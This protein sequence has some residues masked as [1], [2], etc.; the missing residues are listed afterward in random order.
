M[1][2]SLDNIVKAASKYY[3]LCPHTHK[4]LLFLYLSFAGLSRIREIKKDPYQYYTAHEE[5]HIPLFSH[6]EARELEKTGRYSFPFKEEWE[7]HG[8]DKVVLEVDYS[9]DNGLHHIARKIQD[10]DNNTISTLYKANRLAHK[11]NPPKGSVSYTLYMLVKELEVCD[12]LV[13]QANYAE[14]FSQF[15]HMSEGNVISS[16]YEL[17]LLEKTMMGEGPKRIY[18]PYAGYSMIGSVLPSG[19]AI[20]AEIDGIIRSQSARLLMRGFPGTYRKFHDGTFSQNM[21]S[22]GSFDAVV[23]NYLGQNEDSFRDF[24]DC[25]LKVFQD[26]SESPILKPDGCFIGT[27]RTSDFET[28]IRTN[29]EFYNLL[30]EKQFLETVISVPRDLLVIKLSVKKEGE[31]RK[32][33]LLKLQWP[34]V[35]TPL[36][37]LIQT[38][39]NQICFFDLMSPDF[40]WLSH[41]SADLPER[42]GYEIY[43]L[44]TI[45]EP[46][47][48]KM[49][50]NMPKEMTMPT[51]IS[52]TREFPKDVMSAVFNANHAVEASLDYQNVFRLRR[53]ALLMKWSNDNKPEFALYSDRQPSHY[54]GFC[55]FSIE[56][57]IDYPLY[58]LNELRKGYVQKQI[59]ALP[60]PWSADIAA[61]DWIDRFLNVKIYVPKADQ[62][63]VFC[64]EVN[65][66]ILP[67]GFVIESQKAQ[68]TITRHLG[69]GAFGNV[70]LASRKDYTNCHVSVVALKELYISGECVRSSEYMVVP[71][72]QRHD[73]FARILE[74]FRTES[75][76]MEELSIIPDSHIVPILDS[77]YS[78]KTKT[79][80]Y[81]MEYQERGSLLDFLKTHDTGNMD[82]CEIIERFIQPVG[83]ALQLLHQEKRMIHFDV[84]PG[85]I[86]IDNDGYGLLSDFGIAKQ[87]DNSGDALTSGSK[88]CTPE[89]A[90]PELQMPF[91]NA[92]QEFNPGVDVYSL[93]ATLLYCLTGNHPYGSRDTLDCMLA[94]VSS[95]V[96]EAVIRGLEED[97][98]KRTSSIKDWLDLLD[99]GS[100][101]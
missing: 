91:Y 15:L 68:Y 25:V 27:I 16:N 30:F 77:F 12:R 101:E 55:A 38:K 29:K 26:I 86:L 50:F 63:D 23:L 56:D 72:P 67:S 48:R 100:F 59:S 87:Y 46:L 1:D 33:N 82:E 45:L 19:S 2:K 39:G 7:Q 76:V 80:Y 60:L 71:N 9:S 18:S 35:R 79:F 66:I 96:R 53:D 31:E 13:L 20:H 36:E 99:G 5:K 95:P 52:C 51:V 49:A 65:R 69:S 70:Y 43:P 34:D 94:R 32:V 58:L 62:E 21:K 83:K 44:S 89:F 40:S 6:Y 88:Y 98:R 85:N 11:R 37:L 81:A 14:L 74:K 73:S 54:D 10:H 57:I 41:F 75:A 84:K 28:L 92:D 8:I 47:D 78:D 61:D 97:P 17:C 64:Q 3:E 42:E 90:A 93:A 4:P 24:E 22:N